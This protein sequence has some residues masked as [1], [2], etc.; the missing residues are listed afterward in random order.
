M[1]VSVKLLPP[2]KNFW[3]APLT[4]RNRIHYFASYLPADSNRRPTCTVSKL[5][6]VLDVGLRGYSRRRLWSI[7]DTTT[8]E[9]S[10]QFWNFFSIAYCFCFHTFYAQHH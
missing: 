10:A 2:W 3:G 5:F 4:A 9:V 6:P 7:A 8:S 1:N